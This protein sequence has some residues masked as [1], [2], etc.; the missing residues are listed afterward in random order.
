VDCGVVVNVGC[1]GFA[2]RPHRDTG[3]AETPASL[4]AANDGQSAN[5]RSMYCKDK[6]YTGGREYSFDELRAWNWMAKQRERER[7]AAVLNQLR[8]DILYVLHSPVH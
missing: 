2:D 4:F 1:D 6:I 8:S 5:Q 7:H 3:A